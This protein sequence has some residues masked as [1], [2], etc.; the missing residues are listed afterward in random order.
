MHKENKVPGNSNSRNVSSISNKQLFENSPNRL[1]SP[2]KIN[3][4][5]RHFAARQKFENNSS[6]EN[7]PEVIRKYK[8]VKNNEKLRRSVSHR[9]I[10]QRKTGF[11][12]F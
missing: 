2:S 1:N 5:A 7:S 10:P 4:S 3:L 11:D 6:V 9:V 8:S 12:L